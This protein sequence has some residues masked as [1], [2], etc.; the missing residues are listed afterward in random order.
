M[1]D[2][3]RS[4][5]GVIR[6]SIVS[7]VRSWG[8]WFVL[9]A[10]VATM[11]LLASSCT[12]VPPREGDG[13][14]QAAIDAST[15]K[16]KVLCGYQMW[17]GAVGDGVHNRWVH[18]ASAT[19]IS[20]DNLTVE[21]WPD[22]TDYPE[23]ERFPVEGLKHSDGRTAYLFS[24]S[25][26]AVVDLHFKW[27]EEYGID[28]VCVQ[29]FVCGLT[30]PGAPDETRALAYAR[31][32]ANRYGR[33]FA[34]EYDMSGTPTDELYERITNDWKHLVDE[35]QI[36]KDG[37]YLH[38]QGKPV[39]VIFGFYPDRFPAE[40]ANKILDFFQNDS[41]YGA[42]VV[43]SGPWWW[44]GIEDS[45][46][47]EVYRRL[48]MIKPWNVANTMAGE[49][50]ST[51]MALTDDWFD[52]MAEAHRNGALY[53]PVVYPGFSWDNLMRAYDQPE[54]AG[55]PIPRRGGDFLWE[56]FVAATEL[57]SDAVFVAMFDEVD[58]GTAIFKVTND[59]P[60]G[61]HFVTYEGLP[62]DFYLKLTGLGTKMF[63]GEIPLQ[64]ANP[65]DLL[66]KN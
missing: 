20:K 4:I 37:R 9:G 50:A 22:L 59:P 2:N 29:R 45:G 11:V 8:R 36:T 10:I 40:V 3:Q 43:G 64:R 34:V 44:R 16:G 7:A 25:R 58:E 26:P 41:K 38:E 33:V 12:S 30:R 48:D 28:G 60:A 21:M 13:T 6:N 49:D 63:R 17:F 66:P 51:P 52:D 55:H 47:P 31:D 5:P 53:V 15:I 1:T 62:S 61:A 42:F 56:Q 19:R 23:S 32:A 18:W 54:K 65:I 35:I 46:W 14:T 57:K 24:S 27:M 39:V